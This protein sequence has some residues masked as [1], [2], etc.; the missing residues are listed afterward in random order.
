MKLK[1]TFN[2]DKKRLGMITESDLENEDVLKDEI[3]AELG[4]VEQSGLILE[5]SEFIDEENREN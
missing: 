1:A 4:W 3:N 5:K 2:I